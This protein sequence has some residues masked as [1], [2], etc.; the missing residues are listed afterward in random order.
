MS[1]PRLFLS[2]TAIIGLLMLAGV[3][4]VWA[5]PLRAPA[6]AAAGSQPAEKEAPPFTPAEIQPVTRVRPVYPMEAKKAGIQGNVK[7][8]VTINKDGSVMD[9]QVLS[10][11]PQLVKA[12][13]EAVQQWRYPPSKV[14]RV[15]IVIVDF[16]LKEGVGPGPGKG[17]G[18]SG[19]VGGGVS[20]G[21]GGGVSSGVG[22]GVSR[23]VGG[24][25]SGGVGGGVSGGVS[26]GVAG[27]VLS[28]GVYTV[29]G[30]V[31]A[32]IPIYK[33]DPPYTKE[34]KAA[35]LEGTVT[36]S[37]IVGVDGAVADVKVIKPFDKGLTENAVETIKTWKFKPAMKAGK[38]VPCK[39]S[40]EVEFKIF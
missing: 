17:G 23:G 38:P 3:V 26:G 22:G 34:A 24:G 36:L 5:F 35:K 19:G 1:K 20:S 9:I 10:G 30:D 21:V 29:G 12:A 11:N 39:V 32:P 14:V 16:T 6:Q 27:G 33:P 37:I 31:S 40:V 8:R 2:L 4:G 25:V 15:T 18:V 13:F 28:G 7:L